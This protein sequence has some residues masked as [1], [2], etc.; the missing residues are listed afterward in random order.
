MSED[1][2]QLEERVEQLERAVAALSPDVSRRGALGALSAAGAGALLGAGAV[3]NAQAAPTNSFVETGEVHGPNGNRHIDL[4]G[5]GPTQFDFEVDVSANGVK[6]GA[7]VSHSGELA[8][9]GDTLLSALSNGE[10]LA[11]GGVV[12]SSIQAAVN[13]ASDFVRVGPGTFNESVS[14]G[15]AELT[16]VGSGRGTVIDGGASAA[17]TSDKNY[18]TVANL[19]VDSSGGNG[20]DFSSTLAFGQTIRNVDVLGSGAD[21]IQIDGSDS[22][23]EN[24]R[25]FGSTDKAIAASAA[26]DLRISG[27]RC[28]TGVGGISTG[29]A[30]VVVTNC[31]LFDTNDGFNLQGARTAVSNCL[32][33]DSGNNGI[34][35]AGDDSVAGD[36]IIDNPGNHGIVAPSN[37]QVISDNRIHSAGNDGISASGTDQLIANNRV[38][39][40]SNSNIDTSSATTPTTDNNL[41]GSA[42]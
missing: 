9:F 30:N 21:A 40:A 25:I 29:S 41:T 19:A 38:S 16:L 5:G 23:V 10:V 17:V 14:I 42:N 32:V 37:D 27:V 24:V 22:A 35:M 8:D 28:T 15:T 18:V 34:R 31:M 4:Q 39:G 20:I 13:N 12:Y 36:N 2:E 33:K 11:D 3:G 1:R 7:G 6:D 26:D